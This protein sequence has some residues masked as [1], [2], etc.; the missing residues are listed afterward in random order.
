MYTKFG[1]PWVIFEPSFFFLI[2]TN[3]GLR[4]GCFLSG[5]F[6]GYR[7]ERLEYS[8]GILVIEFS[9]FNMSNGFRVS[10]KFE[11]RV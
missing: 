1:I 9:L 5:G 8:S 4:S 10:N 7:I 6:T 3:W 11:I 2:K